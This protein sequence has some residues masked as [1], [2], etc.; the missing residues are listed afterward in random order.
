MSNRVKNSFVYFV[1]NNF[2]ANIYK[3]WTLV[4]ALAVDEGPHACFHAIYTATTRQ[5]EGNIDSEHVKGCVRARSRGCHKCFLAFCQNNHSDAN[6]HDLC[7]ASRI[8]GS[9]QITDKLK[10]RRR[11]INRPR[12]A[13]HKETFW[14]KQWI[15]TDAVLRRTANV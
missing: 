10:R 12:P 11:L 9:E 5:H 4:T 3:N 7:V 13:V 1:G 8:I 6:L 2:I 15:N 14:C